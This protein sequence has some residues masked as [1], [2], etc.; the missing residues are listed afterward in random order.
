[1]GVEL[2]LVH[3]NRHQWHMGQRSECIKGKQ[4]W[5]RCRSAHFCV[6]QRKHCPGSLRSR[7]RRVSDW[8]CCRKRRCQRDCPGAILIL[9]ARYRDVG[10]GGAVQE[11]DLSGPY[12]ENN[13]RREIALTLSKSG[14]VFS[15]KRLPPF[16]K[17][18]ARSF[19]LKRLH[20]F[21]NLAQSFPSKD[22]SASNPRS[23]HR[24]ARFS[25]SLDRC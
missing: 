4:Q 19:P 14:A 8:L 22:S 6:R 13:K 5:V 16:S 7:Q 18:L 21:L 3:R 9:A 24:H 10:V 1:M 17:I 2:R 23:P 25:C 11:V 12:G 15:L 20:A